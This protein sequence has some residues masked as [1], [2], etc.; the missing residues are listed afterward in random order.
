MASE[1]GCLLA[2]T[3]WQGDRVNTGTLAPLFSCLVARLAAACLACHPCEFLI[4]SPITG[5]DMADFTQWCEDSELSEE[6]TK[7][8][9]DNG[10]SSVT[11]V[12]LLNG[13]L[14]QKHLAK[15]L[16]LGQLLLLQ[17][18]VDEL[19]PAASSD[20]VASP[21]VVHPKALLEQQT[22]PTKD[23]GV[24]AAG[25]E[26]SPAPIQDGRHH[27]S[28]SHDLEKGLD[29]TSLLQLLGQPVGAPEDSAKGKLHTFD[30]FKL[31]Q[32]RLPSKLYEVRDYV[33]LL[34]E[35]TGK[36]SVMLGEVEL[37]IPSAKPKVDSISPLQYMEASLRI[38]REM[39]KDGQSTGALL[40]CVGYLIKVASM[41]QRF[42]WKS[43]IQYD[44]GITGLS[45]ISFWCWQHLYDATLPERMQPQTS[46]KHHRYPSRAS[47][48]KRNM[49]PP[50][51]SPFVG[52]SIQHLGVHCVA[53]NLPTFAVHALS[54]TAMLPTTLS[55]LP[56][57]PTHPLLQKTQDKPWQAPAHHSPTAQEPCHLGSDSPQWPW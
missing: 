11:A 31:D 1:A 17:K 4:V 20:E 32:T 23:P 51:V 26:A 8:L 57:P 40:Q 38:L 21:S 42:L 46:P 25:S 44:T 2:V 52:G 3:T 7:L 10:F 37:T 48:R 34:P 54:R 29:T 18:A 41:G 28:T 27:A 35:P 30:P 49:T 33:T 9:K 24:P 56:P 19:Q 16:T 5:L 43:V 12:K 6:T 47:I 50:V 14:I 39:A 22:V 13:P 15:T 55:P 45:R 36:T 53:A